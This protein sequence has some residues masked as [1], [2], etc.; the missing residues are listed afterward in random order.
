MTGG[1]GVISQRKAS[2]S[3]GASG[4]NGQNLLT[5]DPSEGDPSSSQ[6]QQSLGSLLQAILYLLCTWTTLW[7]LLFLIF[8]AVTILTFPW[9]EDIKQWAARKPIFRKLFG[10]QLN[11]IPL[12]AS[13]N[14]KNL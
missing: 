1:E 13:K 3:G 14:I 7:K 5:V 12:Q 2:N 10:A 8:F 6:Q 9:G 11:D 4:I